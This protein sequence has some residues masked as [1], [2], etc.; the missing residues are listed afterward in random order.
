MKDLCL[1]TV[2]GIL[3]GLGLSVIGHRGTVEHRKALEESRGVAFL[4]SSLVVG[5]YLVGTAAGNF[6][7]HAVSTVLAV[8]ILVRGDVISKQGLAIGIHHFIYAGGTHLAL[9]VPVVEVQLGTVAIPQGIAH[10]REAGLHQA[11]VLGFP[12]LHAM[13]RRIPHRHHGRVVEIVL[14]GGGRLDDVQ[15]ALHRLTVVFVENL[16]LRITGDNAAAELQQQPRHFG[17]HHTCRLVACVLVD[18][19]GIADFFISVEF[20]AETG[21]G[22]CVSIVFTKLLTCTLHRFPHDGLAAVTALAMQGSGLFLH[23]DQLV[24]HLGIQHIFGLA[25]Q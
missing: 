9:F 16:R 18:K 2:E 11:G 15:A 12:F 19:G 1:K 17:N 25:F 6:H 14:H 10:L 21:L 7:G 13:Y 23:T 20:F 5:H 8:E 3:Y 22:Q 4:V 24:H